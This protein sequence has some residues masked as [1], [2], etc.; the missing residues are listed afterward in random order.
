MTAKDLREIG[1]EVFKNELSKL[2][3]A[4]N[5][6][7]YRKTGNNVIFIYIIYTSVVGPKSI[8]SDIGVVF[9]E[10]KEL[11]NMD[12]SPTNLSKIKIS[13][14]PFMK[15]IGS[16]QFGAKGWVFSESMEENRNIF[17]NLFKLFTDNGVEFIKVLE[18]YPHPFVD[19]N[20]N[21]FINDTYKL[22]LGSPTFCIPE[23]TAKLT[24]D[25]LIKENKLQIANDIQRWID[26]LKNN[27]RQNRV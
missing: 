25:L 2:G 24:I 3:F 5:G 6:Y 11:L 14:C 23:I 16:N 19:F 20:V 7:T 13:N 9:P 17:I 21:D 15:R 10:Y 22:K 4:G 26:D 27:Y 12:D 18:N 1:E 8:F